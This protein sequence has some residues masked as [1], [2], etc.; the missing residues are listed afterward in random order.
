MT[1]EFSWQNDAEKRK[2]AQHRHENRGHGLKLKPIPEGFEEYARTHVATDI[3]L[4]FEISATCRQ[5][6]CRDLG[7][8]S[9]KGT[10][11]VRDYDAPPSKDL[12]RIVLA[13]FRI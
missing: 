11:P 3:E 5:R 1:I 8:V 12:Y 10:R 9:P 7:I 4:M 6:M 2:L 13:A